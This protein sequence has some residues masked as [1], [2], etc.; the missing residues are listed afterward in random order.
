LNFNEKL[1]TN[2]DGRDFLVRDRKRQMC[3]ELFLAGLLILLQAGCTCDKPTDPPQPGE[4]DSG[5]QLPDGGIPTTGLSPHD[6]GEF[7]DTV[8]FLYE[9]PDAV[10]RGIKPGTLVDKRVAVL[11]GKVLSSDMSP[12]GGV[13]VSILGKPEYGT[14]TSRADGTYDMVVNGGVAFTLSFQKAGLLPSQRQVLPQWNEYI[15]APDTVLIPVDGK[16]TPVTFGM[17]SMQMVSG[18]EVSDAAGQR[19]ARMVFPSGT[20]A[21]LT[22]PNGDKMLLASGSFRAT[23]YS[24]GNN[25]MARMPGRLPDMSGYTYAVELSL[26]ESNAMGA[27]DVTFNQPT[28]FYVDNH[29]NFPVGKPVPVG[30]YDRNEGRWKPSANGRIVA[31][32][33]IVNG[34]ASLDVDG[35][36]KADTG[37]SLQKLGVTDEELRQLGAT[38][39]AGKQLWRV[40]VTHFTPFD[41]N[42]P[43][44]PGPGSVSPNQPS[45]FVAKTT[46][47]ESK[48]QG[49]IIG[50]EAQTL[51]EVFPL[52]G[53]GA[54]LVYSSY[55]QQGYTSSNT[56]TV[57]LSGPTLPPKLKGFEVELR[58]AGQFHSFKE[59]P[60]ASKALTFTWN[61]KDGYGR[62]VVGRQTVKGRTGYVYEAVYMEAG[63]AENEA[64]WASVGS[65]TPMSGSRTDRTFTLLQDW[66]VE[67]GEDAVDTAQFG[68]LTLSMHHRYNPLSQRVSLGSGGETL[69]RLQTPTIQTVAGNGQTLAATDNANVGQ[70]GPAI[71]APIGFAKAVLPLGDGSFLIGENCRIRK[72]DE[73]GN[74][75][76]YAGDIDAAL[77]RVPCAYSG[78]GGPKE[79]AKFSSIESLAK[80]PDGSILVLDSDAT[81]RTFGA[82]IRRITSDGV[83]SKFAGNGPLPNGIP[84]FNGDGGKATDAYLVSI[85]AMAVDGEGVVYLADTQNNRIRRIG[86][87]GVISTVAGNGMATSSRILNKTALG[88]GK[89]ARS[90]PLTNVDSLSIAADGSLLVASYWHA[91]VF[92]IGMDGIVHVVAGSGNVRATEGKADE[93]YFDS[94]NAV[95]GLPQGGFLVDTGFA[96]IHVD[97]EGYARKLA[98]SA[99]AKLGRVSK[100][101][102]VTTGPRD[103]RRFM[104]PTLE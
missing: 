100:A 50:C 24:V 32:V 37:A 97:G 77:N 61:G 51:S 12:L 82:H 44:G 64:A 43:Y 9:G 48:R 84:T 18:S 46:C 8:R 29:L 78:D 70:G 92:R 19:T 22:L 11:R 25:G 95:A 81:S 35:D 90:V 5:T 87:D 34:A 91:C 16:A 67:V 83:I 27:V 36:G 33:D 101:L 75:L 40:P 102:V 42:W 13:T 96:V 3:C 98:G 14:G 89:P 10:Q 54:S 88:D 4:M 71:A 62:T 38:Y 23:E 99:V 65:G 63:S 58:V 20:S 1:S 15:F 68:G 66:S 7:A 28:Y 41:H 93:L 94:V 47:G 45:P 39:I 30:F 56:L 72:V 21:S 103:R 31:I 53:T 2:I 69:G 104:A 73:N 17:P 52:T 26:D 80:L 74:I 57:P 55:R 86:L 85:G 6:I 49:S 79:K 60:Q 59:M 76:A